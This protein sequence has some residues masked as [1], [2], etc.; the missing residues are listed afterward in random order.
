MLFGHLRNR[1]PQVVKR[2]GELNRFAVLGAT[3]VSN[4]V[5]QAAR[6]SKSRRPGAEQH[7]VLSP[8]LTSRRR[9][10]RRPGGTF[11]GAAAGQP[12]WCSHA[13]SL[14]AHYPNPYP[15]PHP[16]QVFAPPSSSRRSSRS[17]GA[18]SRTPSTS[19]SEAW[20][21]SPQV[22]APTPTLALTNHLSHSPSPFILALALAPE[23]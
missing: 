2:S 10:R 16:H 21:L 11:N 20:L 17:R 23:E 18:S 4:S 19:T 5:L 3:V 14:F 1:R 8:T 9:G 7:A 12:P 13:V 22:L 6:A 15:N